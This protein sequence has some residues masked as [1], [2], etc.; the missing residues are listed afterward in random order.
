M[1]NPFSNL[2]SVDHLVE[3]VDYRI[4]DWNFADAAPAPDACP[5]GEKMVFGVC[6]KVG[7]SG[8][9]DFD[10]SKKTSQEEGVEAEA[11]KQGSEFKNNK[12]VT[13]NGKKMGW[14]MKGG[15]PVMVEWGSV[16][17]EKKV[18]P[19]APPISKSPSPKRVAPAS[20]SQTAA[21]ALVNPNSSSASRQDAI[22][23]IGRETLGS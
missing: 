9:K 21:A 4:V 16:A 15:K 7:G 20:T 6:R 8:E 18:G 5:E 11:K 3:G 17:G 23:E 14:A 1:Y 22:N 19:K 12:Q 10:S 2:P 13:V